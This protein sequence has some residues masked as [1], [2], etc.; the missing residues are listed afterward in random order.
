MFFDGLS[1]SAC[2]ASR[3]DR[4]TLTREYSV[5]VKS[6]ANKRMKTIINV[7]IKYE[8]PESKIHTSF[9]WFNTFSSYYSK[10]SRE[11]KKREGIGESVSFSIHKKYRKGVPLLRQAREAPCTFVTFVI[12]G[13][14]RTITERKGLSK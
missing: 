1:R 6:T 9:K 11:G 8:G 14:S 3:A 5:S 13:G 2:K 10:K 7:L 12:K 4:R